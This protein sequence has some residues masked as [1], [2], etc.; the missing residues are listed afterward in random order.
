MASCTIVTCYYHSPAKH[1]DQSYNQWMTNF[2]T[3]VD[4]EMVIFCDK[5]SY[6]KIMDLRKGFEE[7]TRV[8]VLELANTFCGHEAFR[9]DWEKDWKRDRERAIH[10]P[11]LYIIWNEKSMFVKR[12][13]ELQAFP[14]EF[15]MWC[16][17]GCFRSS[18]DLALFR[19]GW[20]SKAFLETAQRNK[21]YFLNIEPFVA[22]DF[23]LLPNGFTRSF[24]TCNRIGGTMFLGHRQIFRQW[25]DTYYY[26]LSEYFKKDYFAG[27]DQ[28]IMASIYVLHPNLFHLVRPGEGGDPWF[29]LQ[30]YFLKATS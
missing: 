6:E 21:M 27:K 5:V 8:V 2:L 29:Y 17:I 25:I 15:Y 1:S 4:N 22:S 30:R 9:D 12:A 11:N 7:K 16:D 3:T 23:E 14:T 20:P 13:M 19:S 24:E 18:E 10:N 28:N 26:Y